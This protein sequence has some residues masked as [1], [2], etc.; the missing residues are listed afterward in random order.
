[1]AHSLHSASLRFTPLHSASLR[2]TPLRSFTS[3][4]G[5]LYR[6]V[7]GFQVRTCIIITTLILTFLKLTKFIFLDQKK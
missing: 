4:A 2:F 6:G 5:V 3:L 1:M 7:Q